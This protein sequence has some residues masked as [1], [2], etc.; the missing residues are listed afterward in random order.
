MSS[1]TRA[2]S[3]KA[4]ERWGVLLEEY[5]WPGNIR[6]LQNFIELDHRPRTAIAGYRP[7]EFP[8]A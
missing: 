7:H 8:T 5:N 6:E 1:G 3:W 2:L 4:C